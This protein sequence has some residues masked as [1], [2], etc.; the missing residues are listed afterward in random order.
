M[1][2]SPGD[3]HVSRLDCVIMVMTPKRAAAANA[4]GGRDSFHPKS[5]AALQNANVPFLI[6]GT[7]VIEAYAGRGRDHIDLIFRAG[8]GTMRSR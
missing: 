2:V 4:K 3:A 8:N 6:G 7:Y 5:M 1:D